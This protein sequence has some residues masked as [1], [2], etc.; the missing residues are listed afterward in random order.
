[1]SK[2]PCF[3][4]IRIRDFGIYFVN[5]KF[6]FTKRNL[7]CQLIKILCN[8]VINKMIMFTLLFYDFTMFIGGYFYGF[9]L[10]YMRSI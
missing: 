1:M 4:H 2:I 8:I 9:I 5:R 7:L 6:A 3:K 10:L